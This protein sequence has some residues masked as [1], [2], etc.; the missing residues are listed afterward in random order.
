V[1]VATAVAVLASALRGRRY[2]HQPA[3]AGHEPL[4]E[5]LA[6]GA[7]ESAGIVGLDEAAAVPGGTGNGNGTRAARRSGNGHN[8]VPAASASS[9]A[10]TEFGSSPENI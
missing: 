4:A 6:E 10:D 5:E 9:S 2:L 1:Q 3:A 7:A 8:G